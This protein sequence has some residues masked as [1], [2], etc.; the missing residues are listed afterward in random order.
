VQYFRVDELMTALQV[1]A[2]LCGG[3]GFLDSRIS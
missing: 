2:A 1:D 3:F